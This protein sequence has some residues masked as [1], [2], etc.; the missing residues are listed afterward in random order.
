MPINVVEGLA[1][2]IAIIVGA[3]NSMRRWCMLA[4]DIAARA[5]PCDRPL[6]VA[7]SR[8]SDEADGVSSFLIDVRIPA[9]FYYVNDTD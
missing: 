3:D 1:L 6:E 7:A 2:L 9:I 4:R 8:E 5:Q